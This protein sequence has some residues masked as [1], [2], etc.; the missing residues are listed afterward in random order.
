MDERP[1]GSPEGIQQ[2]AA[3]WRRRAEAASSAADTLGS[4]AGDISGGAL[5]LRGDYAAKVGEAI[6]DLPG[7]LRKLSGGRAQR[8]G[9]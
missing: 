1:G 8:V 5:R 9:S 7:E 3:F 6:G 4:A 2:L